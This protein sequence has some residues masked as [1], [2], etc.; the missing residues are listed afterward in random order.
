[1]TH[2]RTTIYQ[3]TIRIVAVAS[4]HPQV[5]ILRRWQGLRSPLMTGKKNES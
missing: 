3:T 1:M 2:Q 5:I 4:I